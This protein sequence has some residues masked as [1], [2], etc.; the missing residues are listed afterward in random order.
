MGLAGGPLRAGGTEGGGGWA[1][2]GEAGLARGCPVC[3]APTLR[4][5]GR[6][7][8]SAGH[9]PFW[10]AEASLLDVGRVTSGFLLGGPHPVSGC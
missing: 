9:V 4:G 5:L 10:A 6:V 8:A 3:G 1:G 7:L 2:S